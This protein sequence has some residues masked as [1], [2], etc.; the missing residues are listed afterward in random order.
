MIRDT[1]TRRIRNAVD[2]SSTLQMLAIFAMGSFFTGLMVL[3]HW[4]LN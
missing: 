3:L 4:L 1:W 2:A